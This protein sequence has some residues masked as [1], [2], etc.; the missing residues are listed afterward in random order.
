MVFNV[1]IGSGQPVFYQLYWEDGTDV[2]E[3]HENGL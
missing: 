1:T 2:T 3:L